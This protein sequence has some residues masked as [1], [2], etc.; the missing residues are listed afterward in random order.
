MVCYRLGLDLIELFLRIRQFPLQMEKPPEPCGSI[1][2]FAAGLRTAV[3]RTPPVRRPF[4][5]VVARSLLL[6]VRR[7]VIRR[8]GSPPP[9]SSGVIRLSRSQSLASPVW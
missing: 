5:L 4:G 1:V 3:F 9:G 6:W 8:G 2:I 7:C